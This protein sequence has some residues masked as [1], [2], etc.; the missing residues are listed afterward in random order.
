MGTYDLVK[1]RKEK[2]TNHNTRVNIKQIR[3]VG[4]RDCFLPFPPQQSCVDTAAGGTS[5]NGRLVMHS[6]DPN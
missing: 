2:K 3:R 4:W 1:K 6:R 5:D